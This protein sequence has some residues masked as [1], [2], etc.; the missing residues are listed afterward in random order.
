MKDPGRKKKGRPVMSNRRYRKP[1]VSTVLGITRLKKRAKKALGINKL[2]WPFRAVKNYQRRL[3]RRAGYYSPEMKALRAAKQGKVAGPIGAIHFGEGEH[4]TGE[5]RLEGNPLLLAALLG[6]S[7]HDKKGDGPNPLLLAALLGQGEHGAEAGK[8]HKQGGGS[9]NLAEA[10]LLSTAL[11]GASDAHA[12]K[13]QHAEKADDA[14]SAAQPRAP[15]ARRAKAKPAKEQPPKRHRGL[16]LFGLL[17][18]VLLVAAA[19]VAVWYYWVI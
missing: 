12:P 5:K 19:I 17:L 3:L 4:E 15:R 11:K 9:A 6:Q 16:R 8:G 10:L 18:V 13:A 1:S 7:E 2:L 14:P